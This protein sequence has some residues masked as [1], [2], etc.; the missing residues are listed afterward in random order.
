MKINE[1]D[2]H[3][4]MF[5]TLQHA[6]ML[7]LSVQFTD[8]I[9]TYGVDAEAGMRAK[10]LN[11]FIEDDEDPE[12]VSWGIRMDFGPYEEYNKQFEKGDFFDAN[13]VACL[14]IHEAGQYVPVDTIFFTLEDLHKAF[15]VLDNKAVE[16]HAK[17]TELYKDEGTTET[18]MAWLERTLA[19]TL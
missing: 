14:T 6:C 12:D 11:I 17:L 7:G 18:Y 1:T 9:E 13:G 5:K 19:A 4:E 8:Y 15:V 16:N 2:T 10:L 3:E